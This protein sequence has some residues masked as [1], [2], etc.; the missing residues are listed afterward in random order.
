MTAMQFKECDIHRLVTACKVYQE[1]T[2]SEYMWDEYDH[3]QKRL[4]NY[5]EQN[6]EEDNCTI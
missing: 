6:Y 4:E 3:L 1:Q 2:G 5:L